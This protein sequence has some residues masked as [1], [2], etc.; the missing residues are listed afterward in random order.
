MAAG[1]IFV[2]DSFTSTLTQLGIATPIATGGDPKTGGDLAGVA[3]N[4]WENSLAYTSSNGDHSKTSLTI[5]RKGQKPVV[6]DLSGYEKKM[7]PD[8]VNHYGVK[9]PSK[10][11]TDALTKANIPVSYRGQLD[12]HPYAV[13]ALGHG[14]WAVADAGGNDILKVDSRGRVSTIAVLPAQPFEV[15]ADFAAAN[16]LPSCVVGISYR[17]EPVPT[18][19][20]PGP[21]GHLY[22]TTLPG[23]PEGPS[24]GARGSV[25]ELDHWGKPHRIAT[26]F[27]GAT[28]LAVDARGHVFVAELGA[29][30]ISP[31]LPRQAPCAAESAGRRRGGVR[32]WPAVRLHRSGRHRHPG[33][34]DDRAAGLGRPRHPL[35]PPAPFSR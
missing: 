8:K 23:G 12:S 14:S 34:G 2:A 1:K 28:N 32:R 10:C 11:V 7:N 25:Y 20:E 5:L 15:T 22:V 26:G 6:A 27:A 31:G 24:A 17:F 16:K 9:N 33:A 13:T 35:I 18:D 4:R 30:R 29:A 19:V 3:V 21:D